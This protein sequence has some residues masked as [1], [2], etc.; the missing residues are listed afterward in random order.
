MYCNSRKPKISR[1]SQSN[2]IPGIK[3]YISIKCFFASWAQL[4]EV[5]TTTTMNTHAQRCHAKISNAVAADW[6]TQQLLIKVCYSYVRLTFHSGSFVGSGASFL[7]VS[8]FEHSL[9][10]SPLS[11]TTEL[12][13]HFQE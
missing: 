11:P 5:F 10:S 12:E 13:L 6:P 8:E 3:R 1:N 9:C 7:R 2:P 4:Q